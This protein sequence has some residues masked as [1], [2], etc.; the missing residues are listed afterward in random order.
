[1]ADEAGRRDT[2]RDRA[3]ARGEEVLGRV[4]HELLE[5]PWVNSLL[6]AAL[7]ARGRAAA[8]QEVAMEL[9]NLPSAAQIE[10]LTRRVRS[11]SQRLEGI[12]ETIASVEA[13]IRSLPGATASRL[14]AIEQRLADL[15]ATLDE[16]RERWPDGPVAPSRDQ[17]RMR[18]EDAGGGS[19]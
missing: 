7:E 8:A 16:L 12:E 18:V 3:S 15:A 14:D 1:V 9:L 2:I 10:R 6:S 13:A 4:T 17:E 19:L 5:S 11:A